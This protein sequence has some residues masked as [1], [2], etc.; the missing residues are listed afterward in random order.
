MTW[1]LFLICDTRKRPERNIHH[2]KWKDE[3][4]EYLQKLSDFKCI[5]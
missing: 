5:E 1:Y 3:A 2:K 4:T